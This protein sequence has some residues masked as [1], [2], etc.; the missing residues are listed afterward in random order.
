MAAIRSFF[1]VLCSVTVANA[2]T[3]Y[4]QIP[5]GAAP[6]ST[7]AGSTASPATYTGL[8]AYD[9][10]KL[11]PP[12]P[13]NPLPANA[14]PIVLMPTADLVNGL[15]I[16]TKGSFFGFSIE[17]SVTN[18]VLGINSSFI[19][20]PFLNFASLLV[21][22]AGELLV[23]VG[24]NTQDYAM[25]V[26]ETPD[27]GILGKVSVDPNNPTATPTLVFTNEL[28]YMMAN[29]STL[30]NINWFL[31]VPFNDSVNIHM[32]IVEQGERIL[33][34]H[35]LGFQ[36]GNEP[37]LYAKHFH[38][39]QD[40]NAYSYYQEFGLWRDAWNNDGSVSN[41]SN[42]IGPSLS[43]AVWPL[44]DVWNTPFLTDYQESLSALSVEKYPLDNCNAIYPGN[45]PAVVPQDVFGQYLTH[46]SGIGIV[47]AMLN[48]TMIAQQYQK[49]FIMFETNTASCGGFPGISNSFASSL[50]G[51][52]YGLQMVYSNFSHALVHFGGQNVYYNPFTPPPTN[53]SYFH[54]WTVGP[55]FYSV[56]IMPEVLGKT[57]TARVV[58]LFAN[59]NN[60]F[61]PGYAIYENDQLARVALFNYMTESAG[62]IA[63]DATIQVGGG[64][65]GIPGATPS[66]VKVKYLLADSV[67]ELTNITWAGQT[68]GGQFETDGRLLGE[69]QV[70][71]VQCDTTA[72]TC[73]IHVP[74][75]G[76]A[77]VM[78]SDAAAAGSEATGTQTFSTTAVTK[79]ANTAVV[80]AS[81]VAGSN[82][83]SGKD[84]SSLG[85][86][87]KGSSGAGK[88]AG[89]VP[90]VSVLVT[91]LCGVVLVMKTLAS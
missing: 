67:A 55:I 36:V 69:E 25:L 78:L 59:S 27:G 1:L 86:T 10:T 8:A 48:S 34:Q 42:M 26:D 77:L 7:A 75:P 72:Q 40:Y 6:T 88:A 31:G 80:D 30:L 53:Q 71:T 54:Q 56:M 23:R 9:L 50:W 47:S 5:L 52:D 4:S 32:E 18:Q 33:G 37:D 65:T 58:D 38:R 12:A 81:A 82:G 3:V 39:N 29:I 13:P 35:M 70:Q 46:Q 11:V 51:L 21:E 43:L 68:F 91:V 61:T 90:G 15:G 49:P 19:N 66:S 14:F 85:S 63:Y 16:P 60:E 83:H 84:R 64:N 20:V 17:M 89:V 62:G 22:R 79:T 44:E 74:A 28:L 45:G 76:F 2:V 73:T 87:S 41:K 24:G 57:N